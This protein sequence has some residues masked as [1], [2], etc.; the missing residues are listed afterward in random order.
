MNARKTPNIEPHSRQFC[1]SSG[2][3]LLGHPSA[4][5]RNVDASLF[6]I[7]SNRSFGKTEGKTLTFVDSLEL[8]AG[9]EESA[10]DTAAESLVPVKPCAGDIGFSRKHE[11]N[12]A[13]C[14]HIDFVLTCL[15]LAASQNKVSSVQSSVQIKWS[16]SV[17]VLWT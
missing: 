15:P 6:A 10:D 14:I 3:K 17:I 13:T 9:A 12:M 16:D 1:K 4:T 5:P 7:D 2:L 11:R 8:S